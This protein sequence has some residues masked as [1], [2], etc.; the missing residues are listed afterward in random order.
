MKNH[1]FNC[2]VSVCGQEL[3]NQKYKTLRE[4]ATDLELT[5]QQVA[6]ISTGRF[7]K[8]LRNNFKYAP[9]I[10]IEKISL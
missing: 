1:K 9:E 3:H 6:D 10:K 8:S 2:I 4:I 5:Y 7:R